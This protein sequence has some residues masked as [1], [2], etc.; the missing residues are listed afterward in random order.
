MSRSTLT[1]PLFA[2]LAW[3]ARD[4]LSRRAPQEF[5]GL[6]QVTKFSCFPAFPEFSPDGKMIVFASDKDAKT[7]YEF[8]SSRPRGGRSGSGLAVDVHP[9]SAEAAVEILSVSV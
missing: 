7:P 2:T 5:R 9:T 6:E 1:S 3:P 4:M 8:I